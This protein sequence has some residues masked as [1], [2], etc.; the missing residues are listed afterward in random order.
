MKD[1]LVWV[2]VI[3]FILVI[4]LYIMAKLAKKKLENI[5]DLAFRAYSRGNPNI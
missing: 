2:F 3:Q 5:E 1:W 4:D